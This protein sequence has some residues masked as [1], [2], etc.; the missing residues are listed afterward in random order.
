MISKEKIQLI[1]E[2]IENDTRFINRINESISYVGKEKG[3]SNASPMED[4]IREILIDK[5]SA[6]QTNQDRS[7]ADVIIDGHLVNVKFGSPK[8]S[9]NGKFSYGQP[10]MCAMQRIMK[11][12]YHS[13]KIDSY[14]IIKVNLSSST[15]GSYSLHIFDM[16]DH[17]DF[18]C[19]NAGTGQIMLKETDFY[20]NTKSVEQISL[21]QKREKIKKLYDEG[22]EKHILLRIEQYM[23]NSH[24]VEKFKEKLS[25]ISK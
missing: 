12:F 9:K 8:K 10:N 23:K 13:D 1:R 21:Q 20:R 18:L 7:L 16:M 17:I 5:L 6:T 25:S 14:Y 24:N 3:H 11:L 4:V 2:T 15:G 19:W 22:M